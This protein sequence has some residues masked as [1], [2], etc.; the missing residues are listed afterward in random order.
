[1]KPLILIRLSLVLLATV[2]VWFGSARIATSQIA[3]QSGTNR[4]PPLTAVEQRSY[5]DDSG[6]LKERL[7]AV[8][9]FRVDGSNVTIVRFKAPDG[10]EAENRT[11]VDLSGGRRLAVA[12]MARAVTTYPLSSGQQTEL[13][14]GAPL[15]CGVNGST[16]ES[17]LGF[18]T[19]KFVQPRGHTQVEI[20]RVAQLGCIDIKNIAT[21]T[22][23]GKASRTVHEM[24]SLELGDPDPALFATPSDYREMS[25]SEARKT[26]SDRHPQMGVPPDSTSLDQAY[27]STQAAKEKR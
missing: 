1:M 14:K 2:I 5:Y 4:I 25:P 9:A 6:T 12:S 8:R 11:I 18:Q 20:W 26:I 3:A 22:V 27:R 23:N 17:M 21:T 10:T 16:G 7:E 13:R 19:V 24:T 15:D